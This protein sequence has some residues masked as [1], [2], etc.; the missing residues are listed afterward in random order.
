MTDIGVREVA[1]SLRENGAL[2]KATE[3]EEVL[4]ARMIKLEGALRIARQDAEWAAEGSAD[5]IEWRETIRIIDEA[6]S[7]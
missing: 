6:L 4:L 7:R 1:K 5:A 3:V 2:R